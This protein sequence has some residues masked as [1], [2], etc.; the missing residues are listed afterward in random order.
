MQE[1][2]LRT[3]QQCGAVAELFPVLRGLVNAFSATGM[4]AEHVT[5]AA[6]VLTACEAHHRTFTKDQ[7][8]E[9]ATLALTLEMLKDELAGTSTGVHANHLLCSDETRELHAQAD[10]MYIFRNMVKSTVEYA[11]QAAV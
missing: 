10:L 1:A 8:T 9:T 6:A 11:V 5:R 2:A 4:H 3:E 7:M